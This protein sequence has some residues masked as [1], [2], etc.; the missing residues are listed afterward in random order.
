MKKTIIAAIAIASATLT[1]AVMAEPSAAIY[2]TLKQSVEVTT[3][4]TLQGTSTK[5][6]SGNS[7]VGLT[8]SEDV[9]GGTSIKATVEYGVT[10]NTVPHNTSYDKTYLTVTNQDYGAVYLGK[11]HSLTA[12]VADDTIDL[13]N[14]RSFTALRDTVLGNGIAYVSPS[15]NGFSGG[16]AVVANGRDALNSRSHIDVTEIMGRYTTNDL[17]VGATHMQVKRNGLKDERNTFIGLA[18]KIQDFHLNGSYERAYAG[19]GNGINLWTVGGEVSLS[20]ANTVR[21]A[22]RNVPTVA[23]GYTVEAVHHMSKRTSVFGNYQSL[24]GKTT[25]PSVNVVALGVKHTF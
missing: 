3:R 14:G 7:K 8:V 10:S 15:F 21:V 24:I 2:G 20:N 4:D 17:T 6:D 23:H 25:Y 22:F 18:Y 13:F 1:T 9:G 5:V 11:F 19:Y 12:L 16:A